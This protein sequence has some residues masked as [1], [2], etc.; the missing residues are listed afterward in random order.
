M[1]CLCGQAAG[2]HE[3]QTNNESPVVISS[4]ASQLELDCIGRCI[5]LYA[6]CVCVWDLIYGDTKRISMEVKRQ[7]NFSSHLLYLSA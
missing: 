6:L 5:L 3:D 2:F 1:E 7:A 4:Y